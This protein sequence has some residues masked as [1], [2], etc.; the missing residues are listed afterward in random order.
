LGVTAEELNC[1]V[2]EAF[3]ALVAHA[4]VTGQNLDRVAITVVDHPSTC[5]AVARP[6]A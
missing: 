2:P 1:T 3:A 6:L 4:A 5:S